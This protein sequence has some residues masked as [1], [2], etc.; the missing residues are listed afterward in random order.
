MSVRPEGAARKAPVAYRRAA[1][2]RTIPNAVAPIA[3]VGSV[4]SSREVPVTTAGV[5]ERRGQRVR[6]T[7]PNTP[8]TTDA[9]GSAGVGGMLSVPKNVPRTWAPSKKVIVTDRP[10]AVIQVFDPAPGRTLTSL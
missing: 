7:A 5:R 4:S 8:F 6:T 2:A 1:P 3:Q 9:G 10:V